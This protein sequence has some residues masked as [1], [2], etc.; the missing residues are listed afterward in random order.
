MMLEV[1][2]YDMQSILRYIGDT[3]RLRRF[4]NNVYKGLYYKDRA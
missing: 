1:G 2:N 3:E 4:G